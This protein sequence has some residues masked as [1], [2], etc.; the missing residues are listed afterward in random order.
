[1]SGEVEIEPVRTGG[2]NR[3][4]ASDA[5]GISRRDDDDLGRIRNV[6]VEGFGVRVVDGPARP[7]RHRDLGKDLALIEPDDRQCVRPRTYGVADIGNKN[8]A[9]GRITGKAVRTQSHA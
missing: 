3:D 2:G 1:M 5:A 7:S 9:P 8:E 6:Y 4:C